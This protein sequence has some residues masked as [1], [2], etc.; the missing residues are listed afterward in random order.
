MYQTQHY[1]VIPIYW[2]DSSRSVGVLQQLQILLRN[3]A[4]LADIAQV[5]QNFQREF[6]AQESLE[7]VIQSLVGRSLK[8]QI[9]NR[10][11][12][13]SAYRHLHPDFH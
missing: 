10:T 2:D 11:H 5:I 3:D 6:G 8:K 12:H 9:Q 4:T 1:S 7:N 13:S